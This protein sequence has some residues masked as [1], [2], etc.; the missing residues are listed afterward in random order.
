MT[1]HSENPPLAISLDVAPDARVETIRQKLAVTILMASHHSLLDEG[2]RPVGIVGAPRITSRMVQAVSEVTRDLRDHFPGGFGWGLVDD[3]GHVMIR[4]P[5]DREI[6]RESS[7]VS[8]R[9][10]RRPFDVFTDR[11]E[12]VLKVL[13]AS[14]LP[15]RLINGID[16]EHH[17]A[18]GMEQRAHPRTAYQLGPKAGVSVAVAD[19]VVRW[20]KAEGFVDEG[21]GALQLH[22]LAELLRLWRQRYRG[23]AAVIPASW[24]LPTRDSGRRI[25]DE[26]IRFAG[27]REHAALRTAP[28]PAH[29][30]LAIVQPRACLASFSACDALGVGVVR[31]I[32]PRIYLERPARTIEALGLRP[33][34]PGQVPDVMV[35][36]PSHPESVFRAS[37]PKERVAGADI[38]QCWLDMAHE[39][40]RGEEQA[41]ALERGPLASFF[42]DGS[43]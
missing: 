28:A 32:A 33:T 23:S 21:R 38:I 26:L 11:G 34:L 5:D 41:E 30:G 17:A 16:R 3:D 40:A 12:W 20:L 6:N 37:V 14:E 1:G 42:S 7:D 18:G 43:K 36:E 19:R 15:P 8:S 9:G 2:R 22:R 35:I 4:L 39:R 25:R 13:A 29:G 27:G 31:G 10:L 24:K